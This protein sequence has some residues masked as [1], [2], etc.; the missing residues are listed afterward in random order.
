MALNR[1]FVHVIPALV[2]LYGVFFFFR[3]RPNMVVCP[4]ASMTTFVGRL[5]LYDLAPYYQDDL[6]PLAQLCNG[7]R[8]DPKRVWKCDYASGRKNNV[9]NSVLDFVRAAIETG[10]TAFLLPQN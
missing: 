5:H 1:G 4:I 10:A 7:I 6:R 9:S 2:C 8:W 3:S